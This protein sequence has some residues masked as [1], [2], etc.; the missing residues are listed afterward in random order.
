MRP[1]HQPYSHQTA[2]SR[3]FSLY[4]RRGSLNWRS[5]GSCFI[6]DPPGSHTCEIYIIR[7]EGEKSPPDLSPMRHK[8]R[9][10]LY[11]VRAIL[12]SAHHCPYRF[13][14]CCMKTNRL[15]KNTSSFPEQ[16]SGPFQ[17]LHCRELLSG[18]KLDACPAAGGDMGET[19]VNSHL[20]NN[21]GGMAA[22]DDGELDL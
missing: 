3:F 13:M 12:I 8:L 6:S 4:R 16:L 17:R 22:S 15:K 21:R 9:A 18:Q 5:A 14:D 7:Q 19:P 2:K 20:L 11:K 10:E 1:V